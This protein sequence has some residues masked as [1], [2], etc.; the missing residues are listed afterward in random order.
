LKA[1]HKIELSSAKHIRR[2]VP[3]AHYIQ[4]IFNQTIFKWQKYLN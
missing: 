2:D 3:G 1:K 4:T